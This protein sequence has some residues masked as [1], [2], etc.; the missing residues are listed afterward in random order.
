MNGAGWV[1]LV[2]SSASLLISLAALAF[3]GFSFRDRRRQDRRD[4]FLKVHERLLDPDLQR[5]RR[6]LFSHA[7]TVEAVIE[8]RD[9]HLEEFDLINR[10][11]AMFDVAGM[12]AAKNYIDGRDFLAE[13]GLSYGRC[14]IAADAFLQV[15]FGSVP[16]GDARGWPHFRRLGP[17]AAGALDPIP[18]PRPSDLGSQ[19]SPAE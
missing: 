5:G 1:S 16:G 8:L 12:Y 2:S 7:Q 4:L 13:W 10:S 14:W 11:L 19:A 17:V 3:T 6:L 9:Q 18:A 15:R